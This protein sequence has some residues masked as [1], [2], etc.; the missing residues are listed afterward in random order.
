MFSC[1]CIKLNR[2]RNRNMSNQSKSKSTQQKSQ[3][4]SVP[5]ST[6]TQTPNTITKDSTIKST[7]PSQPPA[8]GTHNSNH[9]INNNT[10][11]KSM[12]DE[13]EDTMQIQL[14]GFNN[15]NNSNDS[16]EYKN[17][18]QN[19]KESKPARNPIELSINLDTISNKYLRE[20]QEIYYTQ[21]PSLRA[22]EAKQLALFKVAAIGRKNNNFPLLLNLIDC[23]LR[24]KFNYFLSNPKAESSITEQEWCKNYKT[25][26]KLTSTINK[27][28]DKERLKDIIEA[29]IRTYFRR[30]CQPLLL[31]TP[32]QIR[33]SIPKFIQCIHEIGGLILAIKQNPIEILPFQ[34][35]LV[36]IPQDVVDIANVESDDDD[37]D[38]FD[39]DDSDDDSDDSSAD[40]DSDD[41]PKP[42]TNKNSAEIGNI[43]LRLKENNIVYQHD[44]K[45]AMEREFR[46]LYR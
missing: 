11:E 18:Y 27:D 1:S 5:E 20:T 41:A 4:A 36:I 42:F 30:Y 17:K 12:Y 6:S 38:E 21:C 39:D 29:A 8:N 7:P 37:S 31:P 14:N 40:Y 26:K 13:E 2:N 23:Y 43:E 32:Y 22:A 16:N 46:N 44:T 9:N 45:P 3:S 15:S 33:D 34:I 35:D 28:K 25:V 24:D 19:K 10:D